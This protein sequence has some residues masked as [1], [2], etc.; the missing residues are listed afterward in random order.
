MASSIPRARRKAVADVIAAK[1]LYVA[2]FVNLTGYDEL[3]A[4]TYTALLTSGASEVS[5]T[6]TGYTTGGYPLASVL[7]SNLSTNGAKVSATDFSLSAATFTFR[8]IV[9]YDNVTKTIEAIIDA[10]A[11]K[12]VVAGTVNIAWNAT[13]GIIKVA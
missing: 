10:L 1:T 11:D 7:S 2:L 9:I 4:T 5:S 13:N 12:P 6:L 3:T 8:Y